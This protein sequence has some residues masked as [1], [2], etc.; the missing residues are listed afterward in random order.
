MQGFLVD[1]FESSARE[2][3]L[4]APRWLLRG[5]LRVFG[6]PLM[7]PL[8][9]GMANS[10]IRDVDWRGKR[11]LD[12][13]CGIGDLDFALAARG[14]E[15]VG[16]E[17]DP[18]KVRD[19]TQIAARWGF[20][21]LRF[22]AGD[23]TRLS[24]M[25]LGR[26][27]AIICLAVLEHIHDDEAV[28]Q[29]MSSLLRPGGFV[30]IEVPSARRKTIAEVEAAD[31]HERPGY[32]DEDVAPLLATAGL[33][34]TRSCSIDPLGL[35]YFWWRCSLPGTSMTRWLYTA[36]APVFQPAIRLST[37]LLRRPGTELC[38]LAVK[39]GDDTSK[40]TTTEDAKQH[41]MASTTEAE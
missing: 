37:A 41:A 21:N 12:V 30:V 23:A 25:N 24:A 16:V 27:D 3:G 8:R 10:L 13:G 17:L 1:L 29:Q 5:Y 9:V 28:L 26:F 33:R 11:V 38:Y 7:K 36:L 39:T 15:A 18:A 22:I 35:N 14:A 19:A 40:A 32:R 4:R 34:V 20:D 31:G 2:Q 6:P